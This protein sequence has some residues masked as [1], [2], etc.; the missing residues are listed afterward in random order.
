MADLETAS[1]EMMVQNLVNNWWALAVRG[2][3]AILFGVMTFLL[4]AVTLASLVLLFGAYTA[5]EGVFNL[6]AAVRG[7][8]GERPWWALVLEGLV[9][10]GAA[11]VTFTVPALTAL[12]L[13]YLIAAWAV[14]T[15][16]FE[17]V[18]A[19]RLRQWIQNEWWLVLSGV[20]SVLFEGLL[21]A[22]PGPGAL[23]VVLWIGAYAIVFGAILVALSFRLRAYRPDRSSQAKM[24]AA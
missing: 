19:I 6:I 18:A 23:A 10:I 14:V 4:P 1:T 8:G 3:I 2:A 22:F 7:R 5:V 16:V 12:V 9:S 24:A 20:L 11:I 15:G 17:I 21:M 13:L